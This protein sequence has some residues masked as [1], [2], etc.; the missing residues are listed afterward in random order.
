MFISDIVILN[1]T[2]ELTRG[3]AL[4]TK[5]T[6]IG[7]QNEFQFSLPMLAAA[8]LTCAGIEHGAASGSG[9]KC[10]FMDLNSF[11]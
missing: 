4:S 5:V 10:P 2:C 9:L 6:G 7:K 1:L 11:V 8:G 3:A